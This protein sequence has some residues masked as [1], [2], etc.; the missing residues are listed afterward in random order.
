MQRE[1]EML[2]SSLAQLSSA[3]A[4]LSASK[5]NAAHMGGMVEGREIM[6]PLTGS[7]YV[8]GAI[9]DVSKV[10]IDIGTGY[11]VEKTP[12]AAEKHFERRATLLKDELDK[13]TGQHTKSRQGLEAV[14]AV[15]QRRVL[16]A[17]KQAAMQA[18]NA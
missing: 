9:A 6:V 17:Q 1:E 8:P 2:S 16:E 4:R 7:I 11:Y 15:L 14:S 5:E 3:V 18:A 13:V 12:V 10:L